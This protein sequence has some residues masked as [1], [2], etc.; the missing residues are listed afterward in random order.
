VAW[1]SLPEGYGEALDVGGNIEGDL[2]VT[3]RLRMS[4]GSVQR[5]IRVRGLRGGSNSEQDGER[6]SQE[7]DAFIHCANCSLD[8]CG[9]KYLSSFDPVNRGMTDRRE[10]ICTRY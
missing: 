4:N 1:S 7:H 5:E 9:R 10:G 8:L 3:V 2:K 6:G